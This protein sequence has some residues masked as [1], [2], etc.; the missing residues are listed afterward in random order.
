MSISSDLSLISAM[1][2]R[3]ALDIPDFSPNGKFVSVESLIL[4]ADLLRSVRKVNESL[5]RATVLYPAWG[6]DDDT[7]ADEWLVP[8][9]RLMKPC[10][11]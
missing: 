1:A 8:F 5:N 11:K 10:G 7:S 4:F 3:L 9:R 2:S 6:E